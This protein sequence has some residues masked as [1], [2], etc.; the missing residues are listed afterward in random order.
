[1][2]WAAKSRVGAPFP[3]LPAIAEDETVCNL[4]RLEELVRLEERRAEQGI[5]NA[6]G[7]ET[8]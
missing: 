4:E 3:G 8:A 2:Q 1:M 7:Y 6:K 5:E